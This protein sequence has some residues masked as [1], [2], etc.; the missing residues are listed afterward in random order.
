MTLAADM[1]TDGRL[2]L[3]C[4][5]LGVIS[6]FAVG[7]IHLRLYLGLYGEIPVISTLFVLSFVGAT[8]VAAGLLLPV[9]RWLGRLGR[10]AGYA[11]PALAVLGIGQAATQLVFLAISERRPLF[12]FQEP[13]YDPSAILASRVTEVA[14][15][16][17][18]TAFLATRAV[19]RR[20]V[21]ARRATVEP[22]TYQRS[23]AA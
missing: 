12:G 8:V 2:G 7:A 21:P 20:A 10:L 4:R 17:F 19:R 23:D 14:T 1:A 6:L 18:L 22:P 11:V 9:E 15:I 3:A 5:V 16:V 13:G